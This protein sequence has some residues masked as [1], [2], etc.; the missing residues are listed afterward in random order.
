MFPVFP[1]LYSALALVSLHTLTSIIR[2]YLRIAHR[3]KM[4]DT[5]LGDILHEEQVPAS[6]WAILREAM[7]PRDPEGHSRAY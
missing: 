2:A 3:H 1:M 4:A 6:R 7:D 5:L